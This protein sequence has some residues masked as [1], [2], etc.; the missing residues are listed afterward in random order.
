MATTKKTPARK[1]TGKKKPTS[2]KTTSKKTTAKKAASKKTT[3]K[4][5][6]TKSIAFH[7]ERTTANF[8]VFNPR[9]EKNK[10]AAFDLPFSVTVPASILAMLIP[11]IDEFQDDAAIID[12]LFSAEGHVTRPALNPI[13]INRKPEGATVTIWDQEKF[14]KPM[15]LTPCNLNKLKVELQT[16][17]QVVLTGQIQHSKYNDKELVRINALMNKAFDIEIKI[18]QM[19]LFSQ[20]P[21]E[22]EKDA[23][24]PKK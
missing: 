13:A 15:V 17:H 14:A 8:G 9:E 20:P 6:P 16:P 23:K 24:D 2:K 19:D 22:P 5:S 1:K 10:G 11:S 21:G 3:Q 18:E 12:E 7:L 4:K